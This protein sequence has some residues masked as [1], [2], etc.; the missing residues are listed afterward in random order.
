MTWWNESLYEDWTEF[1]F[2]G[3]V[4][5]QSSCIDVASPSSAEAVAVAL[6]KAVVMTA[7]IAAA[8]CGNMLVMMTT[9]G[10]GGGG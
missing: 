7:I 2:S 1:N 10:G 4:D 9:E 6:L 5:N 8:V 3:W